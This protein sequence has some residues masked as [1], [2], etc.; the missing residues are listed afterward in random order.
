MRGRYIF[1]FILIAIGISALTDIPVFKFVFA[2]LFIWWGWTIVSGPNRHS[3]WKKR[4]R[5]AD[6]SSDELNEVFVFSGAEKEVHS[7]N[8]SG[9][10][11]VTVFGGGEFDLSKVK[12][13]AGTID[14]ELVAV[15][16]GLKL[17]IPQSWLIKSSIVS[18]IGG[19]DN[20]TNPSKGNNVV[21]R[22]NGTAIFGGIEIS[23]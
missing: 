14:L 3:D 4:F 8:F 22:L 2:L 6:L 19:V 1:G 9:G 16:G 23:N 17:T 20:K 10:K 15:F 5:R 21:L 12:S 7:D 18:I 11:I 13:T